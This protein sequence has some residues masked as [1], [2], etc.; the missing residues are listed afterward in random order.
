MPLHTGCQVI[1]SAGGGGAGDD[2]EGGHQVTQ[3]NETKK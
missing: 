1:N 3:S 2:D